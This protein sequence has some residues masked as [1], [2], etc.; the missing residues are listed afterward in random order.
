MGN[1]SRKLI[2]FGLLCFAAAGPV[3]E[4][5]DNE[6]KDL[7][8]QKIEFVCHSGPAIVRDAVTCEYKKNYER[9]ISDEH[10]IPNKEGFDPDAIEA[11][12]GRNGLVISA[13]V[14][15]TGKNEGRHDPLQNT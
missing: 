10:E 13:T 9:V 5:S 3:G 1:I 12:R 8:N 7:F 4:L 11:Y 2:C 6:K 14:K 15:Q